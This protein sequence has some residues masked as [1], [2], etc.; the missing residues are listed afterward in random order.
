MFFYKFVFFISIVVF[1]VAATTAQYN[2]I[3][4]NAY[5]SIE[6]HTV[7]NDD[8]GNFLWTYLGYPDVGPYEDRNQNLAFG[9]LFSPTQSSLHLDAYGRDVVATNDAQRLFL[10]PLDAGVVIG[11]SSNWQK[12]RACG[13]ACTVGGVLISSSDFTEWRGKSAYAGL[14]VSHKNQRHYGWIKIAVSSNGR[15]VTLEESAIHL[16]PNQPITT[17]DRGDD[18]IPLPTAITQSSIFL[19]IGI[20]NVGTLGYVT[21]ENSLDDESITCRARENEKFGVGLRY[22]EVPL[23]FEAGLIIAS[24]ENRVVS[25]VRN[26]AGIVRQD[27]DL[28]QRPGSVMEVTR[29]GQNIIYGKV[30]LTDENAAYPIGIS[31]FQESFTYTNSV[32][33]G[34]FVLLRYTIKNQ[35]QQPIEGLF[36]GMWVD[37]DLLPDLSDNI[38][39]YDAERNMGYVQSGAN[40]Q[41][42]AG[43][44]VIS[45][46]YAVTT[47]FAT[48]GVD[49]G[50][51]TPGSLR[52][53]ENKWKILSGQT[54]AQTHLLNAD[55]FQITSVGP[56]DIS[57]GDE[58][59][60]MY[61]LVTGD[62]AKDLLANSDQALAVAPSAISVASESSP[63][64][65]DSIISIGQIYPNPTMDQ[66]TL[67][68]S[69]SH[70]AHVEL[71][72]YDLIGRNVHHLVIGYMP[73]GSNEITW[74]IN[75]LVPKGVYAVRWSVN[76]GAYEESQFIV[77]H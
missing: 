61:A 21:L 72:I 53:R 31:V 65:L 32:E 12:T 34:K 13:S 6:R 22:K 67:T 23:F 33:N 47:H 15:Q 46:E 2:R 5:S 69:L 49:T 17:G 64:V 56:M 11:P 70:G 59:D 38:G 25:T 9:L 39:L 43:I 42:V 55:I 16:M 26:D 50:F 8:S 73:A 19:C 68:F 37:W 4:W 20:T 51:G 28:T 36:T 3:Y 7:P 1:Q 14:Q 77:V 76:H 41:Q 63:P 62:G 52:S 18:H 57:P 27:I 66:A 48:I 71:D 45:Q 75:H 24:G 35:S 44:R 60:V 54:R 40:Q 30:E 10:T 74:N 58:V 29:K